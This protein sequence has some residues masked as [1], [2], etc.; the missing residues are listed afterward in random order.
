MKKRILVGVPPIHHVLLSK[1]EIQGLTGL[2]YT[3]K[4]VLYGRN[5]YRANKV[6]KLAGVVARALKIVKELYTFSPDIL[7]LNS[8]LEFDGSTRD[9]ITTLLIRLLYFRKLKII[10]KTHGSEPSILQSQSFFFRRMVIPWLQRN[11][12]AWF[13]LSQE[14]KD[15]V[16]RFNPALASKI[17]ITANIIDA[18]RSVQSAS[19]KKRY[20]LD[21]NKF[22]ILFVGRIVR[23]KGVFSLVESISMLDFRE[24]CQFV[25]VGDGPDM[26]E[27]QTRAQQLN[28]AAYTRFVGFVPEEECDHFYANADLLALPT[29][30]NEGF[31]MALF[32]SVAAGLPIITTQIRAARDHLS[33]PENVLWIDGQSPESV[34]KAITTLY[35][36]RAL[37]QA[38]SKNNLQM[39][40]RFSREQVCLKMSEVLLSV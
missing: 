4:S 18:T 31:P 19:F 5:N 34:G 7:Y 14:E 32:K 6:S 20:S 40:N 25:F 28:V 30:C 22:N 16:A 38:M 36:D 1:D 2:G 11:I 37:R 9:F 24:H 12:D 23:E 33:A 10:V 35:K 3:C 21:G 17:Y 26:Q 13:I 15:I 39:G 27:L 8:R 29:F